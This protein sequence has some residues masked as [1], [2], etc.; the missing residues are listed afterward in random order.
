MSFE[1]ALLRRSGLVECDTTATNCVPTLSSVS[2]RA[3]WSRTQDVWPMRV[4]YALHRPAVQQ[5]SGLY[6]LKYY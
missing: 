2:F 5:A 3:V 1:I 4:E 6:S